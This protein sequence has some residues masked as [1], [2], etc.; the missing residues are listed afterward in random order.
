MTYVENVS[1]NTNEDGTEEKVVNGFYVLYYVGMTDNRFPL[2]NVR[3]ILVTPEGGT[4]NSQTGQTTYTAEEM[5]GAKVKADEL[6]AQWLAGEATEESFIELAKKEST[7]PG[8]KD[9]GGLYEDVYPGQMVTNFNDWCFDESR[10]PGDSG[11]VES[12]YGYH[13]MYYVSDSETIYRD[14]LIQNTLMAADTESWYTALVEAAKAVTN[15][16]D[17]RFEA[18]AKAEAL[19]LE[20]GFAL[21]I[22]TSSRSYQMS[23]LSPFESQYAP[24]GVAYLRYKDQHLYADSMSLADWQAAYSQWQA[25]LSK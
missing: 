25:Q 8:S 3:H 6:L 22:H 16:M 15:D 2:A 17:A 21:P 5:A 9:N 14:M 4:Y 19:L 1:T 13:L 11:I 12:T 10:K 20:H 18:F 7:D 24:F 23:N